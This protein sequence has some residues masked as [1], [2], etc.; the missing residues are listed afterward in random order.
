MALAHKLF[1]SLQNY[2]NPA[3]RIGELNRIWYDSVNNVFRIQLDTVTPGGT[4][5]AGGLS[6]SGTWNASTNTPTLASSTGTN[7]YYYIVATAGSTNLNGITDWQIG[8]WLMYNGTVW[9]KIDQS[10]TVTSVNGQTGD[11]SV[12]TVTSIASSAGTGISITGSP[13]TTSGTL[14]I[15]N[16]APDQTVV[17]TGGTGISTSGTYP[18]FTI[19]NS[20]PDR[21]VAIS[22]GT[23]ISV[24]GTYPNFTVTNTNLSSGGTV[25]SV[26]GTTGSITSTGGTTPILDLTSG[27]VTAGTTGSST[28]IPVVT[29]DTYGRVTNITTASNPQGTVTSVGG[30]GT[31]S[32]ISLSGT[33]AR[34][35]NLTLGGT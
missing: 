6:Y 22:S 3:T 24:T 14:N 15:T 27:V 29:V 1:T 16:T 19:T 8:D 26:S 31:V 5:I 10:N 33:V 2:S 30:T 17:L 12:G 4:V 11:V 9:Q 21:T 23:G 34:S 20:S 13:I 28:L 32:G 25:T 7:G 18:S 35:G